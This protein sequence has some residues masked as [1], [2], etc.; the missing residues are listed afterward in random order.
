[1]ELS[2]L[3]KI[4]RLV[5]IAMV[6]D[7]ELMEKLV[8]KGGNAISIAYEVGNR[9]SADLDFSMADDFEDLEATFVTIERSLVTVFAEEGLHAFDVRWQQRPSKL[10][11]HLK[12]FWG[13]YLLEFKL[14]PVA[15]A[16]QHAG[17]LAGLRRNSLT[18]DAQQNRKF[19]VD[20]SPFEY[21]EL[22][23]EKTLNGYTYYVYPP[24][25][26]VFEKLRAICQQIP[27]YSAIVGGHKSVGRARDF[28]D[29]YT[30][31]HE[32][33]IDST[34][35]AALEALRQVFGAK[36]V[37][38]SYLATIAEYRELHR[39]DYKSVEANVTA[40]TQLLGFDAYFDYVVTNF[41]HLLEPS[42]TS[43][44]ATA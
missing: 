23:V 14:T 41:S 13:G 32:F 22:K 20:I 44:A 12:S 17:D 4:K 42:A 38:E 19:T 30:L 21:C 27:D 28:Y 3:D 5:I 31:A 8:L 11:E 9:G 25:L 29:I 40:G 2:L 1:M 24:Q 7:D 16:R 18:F 10:A 36:R 39:A 35:D 33:T 34:S 37:P 15:Q 26:V 6:A 43:P